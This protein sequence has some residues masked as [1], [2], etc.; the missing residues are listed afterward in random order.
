MV[1]SA[2]QIVL[3]SAIFGSLEFDIQKSRSFIN[4][5]NNMS[6]TDSDTSPLFQRNDN[7][8]NTDKN[9]DSDQKPLA[10]LRRY[11]PTTLIFF[12]RMPKFQ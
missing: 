4:I 1:F 11:Y 6:L 10:N 9:L 2:A 8:S 3:S 5:L 12:V 7:P